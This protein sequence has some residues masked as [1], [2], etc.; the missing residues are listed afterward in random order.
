MRFSGWPGAAPHISEYLPNCANINQ[1]QPARANWPMTEQQR[2]NINYQSQGK[3]RVGRRG[4]STRTPSTST[5]LEIP[6]PIP[7]MC[8]QPAATTS[9]VGSNFRRVFNKN[10]LNSKHGDW[11]RVMM[12]HSWIVWPRR[13]A[14]ECGT[15]GRFKIRNMDCR[16]NVFS[17]KWPGIFYQYSSDLCEA[18]SR[19]AGCGNPSMVA[20][21][22]SWGHCD[23]LQRNGDHWSFKRKF[24]KISQSQRRT[25]LGPFPGWSAY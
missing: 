15:E 25:L 11:G 24:A 16:K 6:P 5:Y 13:L 1:P 19:A 4:S 22:A 7:A 23:D 21:V 12:L 3:F 10:I 14:G 20:V 2:A 8:Q 18:S 17:E 9:L